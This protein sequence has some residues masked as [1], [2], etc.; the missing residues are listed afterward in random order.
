MTL[1]VFLNLV[2]DCWN[3]FI[4][5]KNKTKN[6]NFYFVGN[7][8]VRSG[9]YNE[10]KT[11]AF[12]SYFC[13][14]RVK[15]L[16]WSPDGELI[17]SEHFHSI[18]DRNFHFKIWLIFPSFKQHNWPVLN[19]VLLTLASDHNTQKSKNLHTKFFATNKWVELTYHKA[20]LFMQYPQ[21]YQA[22]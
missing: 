4:N 21:K 15:I 20:S 13:K 6:C 22:K 7:C 8:H 9:L 19:Q 16:Y 14:M 3:L 2:N 12:T 11:L 17:F 1:I 10:T 18:T 5:D